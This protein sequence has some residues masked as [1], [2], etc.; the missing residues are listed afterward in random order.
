MLG[1][2]M[3][4]EKMYGG[5]AIWTQDM[6]ELVCDSSVVYECPGQV[7]GVHVRMAAQRQCS[8]TRAV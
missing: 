4:I 3:R 6:S 8:R 2:G 7:N 1:Y 5:T